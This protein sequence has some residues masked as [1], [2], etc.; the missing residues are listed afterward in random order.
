MCMRREKGGEFSA[1]S[2][3]KD[4]NPIRLGLQPYETHV[5]LVP[6][7]WQLGLQQMNSGGIQVFSPHSEG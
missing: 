5:T 3:C 2:S 7:T 1:V 4:P 6:A